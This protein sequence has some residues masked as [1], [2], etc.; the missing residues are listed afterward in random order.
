MFLHIREDNKY[1]DEW[2]NFGYEEIIIWSLEQ[3]IEHIRLADCE[4]DT[5]VLPQ[6][7]INLYANLLKLFDYGGLVVDNEDIKPIERYR[8]TPNKLTILKSYRFNGEYRRT[9]VMASPRNDPVCKKYI[10][11]LRNDMINGMWSRPSFGDDVD[12]F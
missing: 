2:K 1:I 6:V 8:I 4:V 11:I 5:N 3:D 12:T 7:A 9:Y 10:D